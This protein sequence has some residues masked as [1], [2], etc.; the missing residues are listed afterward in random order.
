MQ[1]NG[2]VVKFT[3]IV[4]FD[5][6]LDFAVA[7]LHDWGVLYAH[8]TW[9]FISLFNFCDSFEFTIS[10]EK[11]ASIPPLFPHGL[12]RRGHLFELSPL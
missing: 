10:N 9:L 3:K 1:Q 12:V 2:F 5:N 11:T 8:D 7:E 6:I 4:T